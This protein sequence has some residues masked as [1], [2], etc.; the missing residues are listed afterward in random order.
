MIKEDQ[1][2]MMRWL[3][4]FIE[5]NNYAWEKSRETQKKEVDEEEK[6]WEKLNKDEKIESSG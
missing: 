6:R 3:V 2:A 5:V 4:Q 1:N